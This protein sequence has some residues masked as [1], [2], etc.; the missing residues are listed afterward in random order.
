MLARQR[1]E[2]WVWLVSSGPHDG[3]GRYVFAVIYQ[4][5]VSGRPT[6][7]GVQ[8]ELDASCLQLPESVVRQVFAKLRQDAVAGVYK[9]EAKLL[10]SNVWIVTH[11]AVDQVKQLRYHL[12]TREPATCYDESQ[13]STALL[14]VGICIGTL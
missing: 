11:H 14:G 5:P 8:E 1:L 4:N 12:R 7:A 2:Q 9:Y 13:M 6:H 3:S 10:G